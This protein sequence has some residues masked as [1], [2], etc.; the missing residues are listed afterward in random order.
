M[1]ITEYSHFWVHRSIQAWVQASNWARPTWERWKGLII[2]RWFIKK[3]CCMKCFWYHEFITK[4]FK[5]CSV[6]LLLGWVRNLTLSKLNKQIKSNHYC[7]HHH[8]Q[9]WH[10]PAASSAKGMCPFGVMM[11]DRNWM[12]LERNGGT[13]VNLKIFNHSFFVEMSLRIKCH[14]NQD[15]FSPLVSIILWSNWY[16]SLE[17]PTQTYKISNNYDVLYQ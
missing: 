16:F 6:H 13:N 5:L 7:L 17:L 1:S 11:L 4:T 14:V 2:R 12:T 9:F 8:H 10:Q 3:L 15:V